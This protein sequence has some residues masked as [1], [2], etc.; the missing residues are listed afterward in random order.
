MDDSD[1]PSR[2]R[3][4]LGKTQRDRGRLLR[5]ILHERGPLIAG[6]Y[7]V[8]PGRCGKPSCKCARGEFHTTAALYVRQEGAQTCVYVPQAKRKHVEQRNRR[9]QRLRKARAELAKLARRSLELVDALQQALLEPYPP[10][11]R[12]KKRPQRRQRRRQSKEVS[13]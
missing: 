13:D 11:E 7:V 10:P 3:K 6:S 2:L 4:E 1:D 9:Y 12:L 5:T 8:Q